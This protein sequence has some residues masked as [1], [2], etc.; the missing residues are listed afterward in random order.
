MT[1]TPV[2]NGPTDHRWTRRNTF[3]VL[4]TLLAM[5]FIALADQ[6]EDQAER[7]VWSSVDVAARSLVQRERHPALDPPVRLVSDLASGSVLIPLNLLVLLA[8]WRRHRGLA[9]LVPSVALVSALLGALTKWLV[10]RPRPGLT[11]YGFPSGHV[12]AAVVFYGAVMYLSWALLKRALWRWA[13][14]G[15][16]VLV[17]LGVAYSRLYLDAHWLTDVLGAVAG[18][19]ASLL[20]A[21]AWVESGRSPGPRGPRRDARTHAA[22]RPPPVLT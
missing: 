8:L 4:A 21:L 13:S 20:V 7:H 17:I 9:L 12:L 2:G 18:G 11:S 14:T 1:Q 15:A 5:L 6:A 19:G 10:A 16:A 22:G 3:I